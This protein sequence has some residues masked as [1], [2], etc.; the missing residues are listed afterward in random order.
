MPARIALDVPRDFEYRNQDCDFDMTGERHG[1]KYGIVNC[2][3]INADL[4]FVHRK[5]ADGDLYFVDNRSDRAENLDA[6]FRV[7][8]KAPELWDAATG[9]TQPASY[10]I[11][12]GRTT[13]PL[14]LEP[15]GTTFVVFREPA[16]TPSRTL[17]EPKETV[18]A[19]ADNA[20]NSNWTV[21]FQPNRGAPSNA[22]FDRL[23][24]W[25]DSSDYGI[26]Y[27]SGSASYAKTIDLP[28]SVFVPGM[29]LWLD[30]G[31]VQNIAEV[32]ING[33]PQGIAW[34]TPFRIDITNALVPGTNQ[35]A[36]KVTN[37]WVNRLIGDQQTWSLKKYAFSDFTPYK[38]DS[39]LLP[40]GLLG[41]VH[42]LSVSAP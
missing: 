12:N 25:S 34:K 20:L 33:K 8:G 28:A 14:R 42:L 2:I 1:V 29:H 19:E 39:P 24:S 26:K 4:M 13:V 31:D 40:S 21:T 17:P 3:A 30:L 32:T 35:I 15:W 10:S 41:P 36:I 18:I 11:A 5:L 22:N 23:T 6:T 16:K 27:F 38:A 9:K 7:D 37:L